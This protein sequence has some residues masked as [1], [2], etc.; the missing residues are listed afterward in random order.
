[1]ELFSITCT[2][3]RARLKVRE[4]SAIGQILACPKCASMVQVLAP[5][6][7]QPPVESADAATDPLDA[8]NSSSG[9]SGPKWSQSPL[10]SPGAAA[11]VA[12]A[13][14]GGQASERAGHDE[15]SSEAALPAPDAE[16]ARCNTWLK[17]AWMGGA[18][19]ALS[20]MVV[21]WVYFSSSRPAEPPN[22]A[23]AE[24]AAPPQPLPP[25]AAAVVKRTPV[26]LGRRWL[27]TD[28]QMIVSL[29]WRDLQKPGTAQAVL[30]RTSALWKQTVEP[31]YSAFHLA[32]Q[33][34]R[35]LTWA[36]TNVAGVAHREWLQSG[37]LVLQLERPIAESDPR[38]AAARL[39]DWKLD[40]VACRQFGDGSWSLPF[41]QVDERT[42][43]TG[44]ED[45]LKGLSQRADHH[46]S[47]TALDRLL[48]KLDAAR[49]A[50]LLIDVQAC[51]KRMATPAWLSLIEPA[52]DVRDDW[53]T[54]RKESLAL[55]LSL[56]LDRQLQALAVLACDGETM[57]HN[58]QAALD[59]TL[60]FAERTIAG[61]ADDLTGKLLSGRLTSAGA[62]QLK[63]LFSACLEA[64][65]ARESGVDESTVWVR[66]AWQGNLSRLALAAVASVP[67]LE[68]SRLARARRGDDENQR[69]LLL[70]LSGYEK[71]EGS[72]PA[73]AGGAELLPPETRLSWLAT[74]L[75]YYGHLDWYEA[76]NFGRPWN[77]IANARVTRRPLELVINPAL[78]KSFTSAG[79]PV[80]HYV[81]LAG[82]GANAGSLSPDDPRAGVFGYQRRVGL[83]EIGDGAANTIALLG[84]SGNLGPWAAGGDATVRALTA[85]PY[86]NGPDGFGSGQPDGMLVGMADGSVRFISQD[87][88][89]Q[90]FEYLATINGQE[91]V[92]M[93]ELEL[94][95][96]PNA[97][98][99]AKVEQP[100]PK[101]QAPRPPQP[102]ADAPSA[103]LAARLSR[104]VRAI[105]LDQ[106][107][108]TDAVELIRQLSGVEITLD[109]DSLSE[110][111]VA[112]EVPVTVGL[113]EVSLEQALSTILAEHGLRHLAAGELAVVTAA[114]AVLETF[115][116]VQ[117]EVADLT[118]QA[119]ESAQELANLA[120]RLVEPS[121]W[122]QAGG[123]GTIEVGNGVL[124][125][126]HHR[127]VAGQLGRFL[128][129]LRLARG[130]TGSDQGRSVPVPLRQPLHGANRPPT[131]DSRQI[132]AKA[133][134]DAPITVHFAPETPLRVITA[135]LE[136]VADVDIL[137]DGFALAAIGSS[138]SAGASLAAN[139]QPLSEALALALD[140]L[141]LSYRIVDGRTLQVTTRQALED[142]LELEFYRVADLL[143]GQ[144]SGEM[145]VERLKGEVAAATWDDAGGAGIMYFD[146]PSACLLVLQTQAVQI[147]LEG[148]LDEWR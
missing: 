15:T 48:G 68:A 125:V 69:R 23:I 115:E 22:V 132:Q 111:G 148:K 92:P 133:R 114:P 54:V 70:G 101:P 51:R 25:K 142:Q 126:K 21:A 98:P 135:Y 32:P 113:S 81:G 103:R 4:A 87:I 59:Q 10:A 105:D 122:L 109:L 138:P 65:R 97:V 136:G 46:L 91:S 6:D 127:W 146:A 45:L 19:A 123:M 84:V 38:F 36:T 61:E 143:G 94:R 83:D 12:G 11:T 95:P 137:F 63:L 60:G 141:G 40:D 110:A 129:K 39:L 128:D 119:P 106:V 53:Q 73:G 107:P 16:P 5:P 116:T 27:P 33:D 58:L 67:E 17:W 47:N 100:A 26:R 29:R 31:L 1:M 62:G 108:L 49:H 124:V 72:L 131:L 79:F 144:M 64:L 74:L 50:V 82:V 147:E 24:R 104:P 96:I 52:Q 80:T 34:I 43:L 93:A 102:R 8:S 71:A 140:P 85:Q 86:V 112:V 28:A 66:T 88:D 55:G 78:G 30:E 134:L 90:V 57:A 118:G 13:A 89:P 117:V 76:L 130:G 41:A 42:I 77:E 44:P 18:P 20:A 7:W 35:R 9:A 3:C 37:V 99:I 121:S 75:P 14:V 56:H 120:Q 139:E 2:T 145:L